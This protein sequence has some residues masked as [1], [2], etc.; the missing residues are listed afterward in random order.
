M[1][2]PVII[3]VYN[4]PEH[5]KRTIEALSENYLA[6]ETEVFIFSD[7]DKNKNAYDK[8]EMV[9][10]YIDSLHQ[11]DYFKSINIIKAKSNQ[12]LANS[13][14]KGVS[15]VI[16]KYGRAIVLEDDLLSSKDFLQYMNEALDYYK[17]NDKIWS[18]SGYN[19]PIKIPNNYKSDIYLSYRGC[20]W[21]WAT[22]AD[23]WNRVDWEVLDYNQ[24]KKNKSLRKQLNSGGRDM[25]EM[26]DLQMNGKIDSWAI[27]W[28][29]TQSK[30][31]MYTIYPV[32]SR[33]K[34]IG[35][36]GTG[37]HSGVSTHYDTELNNEYKKCNFEDPGLND[38]ILKDFQNYYLSRTGYYKYKTKN[39]VKK[40]LG[41]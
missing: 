12:G 10:N 29:Y 17:T 2:A 21:G 26:L 25:A 35:L 20:S 13:V 4:R 3:F 41:M 11:L 34:N 15:D 28:C 9:R 8:V 31:K 32:V 39:L 24:L 18:I 7:A 40:I 16:E 1:L 19:L 33:I 30:L 37:T 22:W 38:Q 5:T 6:K 23:R 36:D 14:I 27:R